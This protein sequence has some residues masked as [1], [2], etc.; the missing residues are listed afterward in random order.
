MRGRRHSESSC[1][2]LSRHGI[3]QRSARIGGCRGRRAPRRLRPSDADGLRL[4]L[5]ALCD[6]HA[7]ARKQPLIQSFPDEIQ[8]ELMSHLYEAIE[9]R[10]IAILES[11]TGTVRR[12]LDAPRFCRGLL[13]IIGAGQVT[14]HHLCIAFLASRQPST[15][16]G[17]CND[18]VYG[19]PEKEHGRR[20]VS[21]RAGSCL[22]Y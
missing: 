9:H 20:S 7:L 5:S 6:V 17:F 14:L 8:L 4:S 19:H 18:S 13:F 15:N 12:A 16:D 3:F 21:N 11:P 10:K 2:A 1:Q 22:L